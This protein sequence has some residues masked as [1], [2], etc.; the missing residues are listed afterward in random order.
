MELICNLKDTQFFFAL[1]KNLNFE[2]IDTAT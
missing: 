2:T 1:Y